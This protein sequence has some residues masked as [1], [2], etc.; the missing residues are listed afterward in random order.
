MSPKDQLNCP[1]CNAPVGEGDV[2]KDREVD[3]HRV[4]DHAHCPSCG[5][6]SYVIGD[7]DGIVLSPTPR[8][9]LA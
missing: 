3:G 9:V 7:E 1:H 8:R 5:E 6:R 4:E 2:H